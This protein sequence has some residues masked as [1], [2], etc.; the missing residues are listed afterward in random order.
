MLPQ[1]PK[2]HGVVSKKS[3]AD[4]FRSLLI[5]FC[6]LQQ[7]CP[8]TDVFSIRTSLLDCRPLRATSVNSHGGADT[9]ANAGL[10]T[11]AFSN[12]EKK[13]SQR[14]MSWKVHRESCKTGG[15][16]GVES[17]SPWAVTC[18]VTSAQTPLPRLHQSDPGRG[19]SVTKASQRCQEQHEGC[20]ITFFSVSPQAGEKPLIGR[21]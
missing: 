17:S 18:C 10:C 9:G 2:G 6:Y 4:P 19:R 1:G 16:D 20:E 8:Q 15:N 13:K 11:Y 21:G 5:E 12:L 3:N 14:S 7:P